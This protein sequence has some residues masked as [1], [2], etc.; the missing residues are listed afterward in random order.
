MAATVHQAVLL[1]EVISGLNPKPGEVALDATLGGG[2]HARAIAEKLGPNG[3]LIGLDQDSAALA[4]AREALKD[5]PGRVELMQG[6]FRDLDKLLATIE[7]TE[8]DLTLFDLGLSS[9]QLEQSGRGFSFQQDEPLL[10]TFADN[11][12]PDTLTAQEIV[13]TWEEDNL[14]DIIYGYGAETFSRRIARAIAFARVESQ[15]TRTGQLVEIIR[16]A[17]PAWYTHRRLHF[18]TKTF[19]ALRLATNDELGALKD[20]LNLAWQLL[21]PGGRLA[22]ITFHSLEARLVKRWSPEKVKVTKPTRE[23]ILKN[24]RARSAQLRIIKKS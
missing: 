2:G 20:G 14:A 15:I 13:N 19:Q 17:V 10:M 6:N 24:P 5:C 12:A 11:P 9:D 4:R 18:A 7:V 1:Q 3:L 16:Q 8:I 21:R 23:E 22:V